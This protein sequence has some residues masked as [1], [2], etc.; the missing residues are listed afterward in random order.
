MWPGRDAEGLYGQL[1]VGDE[2]IGVRNG[3]VKNSG[4]HAP[5]TDD[6]AQQS[7]PGMGSLLRRS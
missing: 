4:F 1:L 6:F 7:Q 5:K 2:L 3:E